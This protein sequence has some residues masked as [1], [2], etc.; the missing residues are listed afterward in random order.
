MIQAKSTDLEKLPVKVYRSHDRL[1]VAAPMPGLEPE[2]IAV[3]ITP[4]E[5]LILRG[6]LRAGFKG[7][8]EVLL[9][10]WQVGGYIRELR[11]P[12]PVDGTIA[13]LTYGNG[14]L[15][16]ALPIAGKTSPAKLGLDAI[17]EARGEHAGNQGH[18]VR[19]ISNAEH[20]AAVHRRTRAVRAPKG[21][22]EDGATTAVSHALNGWQ[23]DVVQEASEESFPASDPPSW[24]GGPPD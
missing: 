9:D 3:E 2:N 18:P 23:Y 6:D 13:N 10:E 4:D 5:R 7:E 24:V 20:L 12:C 1:V 17:G 16:V 19:A 15:V 11:L 14:V 22:A 8:H 21:A